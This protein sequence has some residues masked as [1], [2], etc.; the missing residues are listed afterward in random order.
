MGKPP[1]T[2]CLT[3]GAASNVDSIWLLPEAIESLRR[4]ERFARLIHFDRRDVGL[5]DPIKDDLTLQVDAADAW[6]SRTPV[7]LSGLLLGATDGAR[8]LAAVAQLYQSESRD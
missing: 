4:L 2:F 8:A 5:S 6:W 1:A 3:S 7:E